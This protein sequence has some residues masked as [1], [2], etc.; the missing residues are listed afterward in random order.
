MPGENAVEMPQWVRRRFPPNERAAVDHLRRFIDREMLREIA[1]ADYGQDVDRHLSALEPVWSGGE[2]KE[3]DHWF[4]MEVLELTRWT[5]PDAAK[6]RPTSTRMK[7]HQ[8]RAFCCAVLLSTP[9]FEPDADTLIQML[10]SV[11]VIGLDTTEEAIGRF[12]TWL[13]DSLGHGEHRSI[14]A[15]SVVAAL[16]KVEPTMRVSDEEELV[17]WIRNEEMSERNDLEGDGSD[18]ESPPWLS[19][20]SSGN[21]RNAKW[22]MLIRRIR[23]ERADRPLGRF[24]AGNQESG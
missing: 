24:L 10:D 7:E 12:L 4:P 11:F 6:D 19:W 23:E 5:E 21:M 14:F 1:K 15:L 8:M 9:N 13:I 22:K 16:N 17:D 3:L 18:Y 20:I 2:F